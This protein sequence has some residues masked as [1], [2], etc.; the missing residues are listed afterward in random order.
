LGPEAAGE[1]AAA[2]L[3]EPPFKVTRTERAFAWRH[4]L[5]LDE[6]DEDEE[7]VSGGLEWLRTLARLV[8]D[9]LEVILWVGAGALLVWIAV[10]ARRR[11]GV[12]RRWRPA[13]SGAKAAVAAA[14]TEEAPLPADPAAVA[15]R[16]LAGGRPREALALLYRATVERLAARGVPRCGCA[17]ASAAG[18]GRGRR[19]P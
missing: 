6:A 18:C 11:L 5:G 12:G 7:S 16:L 19:S 17:A 9:T 13:A 1:I 8:A 14:G 10:Q 4:G 15:E 2:V 3:E